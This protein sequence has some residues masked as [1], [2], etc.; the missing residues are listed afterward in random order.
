MQLMRKMRN[1]S[2]G[3]C[4]ILFRSYLIPELCVIMQ[5]NES[6]LEWQ[7]FL[8]TIHAGYRMLFLMDTT[9]T[10]SSKIS[11]AKE[12]KNH[13]IMQKVH[14]RW[15]YPWHYRNGEDGT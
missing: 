13:I 5:A 15:L 12:E 6:F 7:S 2:L 1:W 9:K 3:S 14:E 4:L 10:L 8:S 11:Q